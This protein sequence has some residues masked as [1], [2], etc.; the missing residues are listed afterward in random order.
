MHALNLG[1][2]PPNTAAISINDGAKKK[3]ITLVSDLKK[4]GAVEIIY[5][6]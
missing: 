1:K 2:V 3:I 4:S 6:P 5:N